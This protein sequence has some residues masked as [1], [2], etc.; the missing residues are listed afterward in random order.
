MTVSY[1]LDTCVL[2]ADPRALYLF[3]EHEVVLPLVVDIIDSASE[4]F[5]L[6]DIFRKHR[7]W[8]RMIHPAGGKG[9][10]RLGP[11]PA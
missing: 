3:D 10:F 6:R 8:G 4:R 11:P 2:L 9:I 7:A 1:V 5:Q